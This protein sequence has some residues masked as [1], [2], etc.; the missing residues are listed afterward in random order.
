M[1]FLHYTKRKIRKIPYEGIYI[2]GQHLSNAIVEVKHFLSQKPSI[3]KNSSLSFKLGS[4][5]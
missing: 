4:M 3:S 2:F 1:Y 5:G